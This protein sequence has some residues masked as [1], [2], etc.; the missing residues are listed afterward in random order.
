[1]SK[2]IVDMGMSLDGFIT[3]P[4][5]DPTTTWATGAR[6]YTGGSTTSKPGARAK[7]SE[8]VRPTQT[9]NSSRRR[10]PAWGPT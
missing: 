2:V 5:A 3:G 9:T 8:A 4:N 6:E 7:A 10:T 1:M